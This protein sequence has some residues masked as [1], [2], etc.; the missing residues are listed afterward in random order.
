MKLIIYYYIYKVRFA[1]QKSK[2]KKWLRKK[3][4]LP[5]LLFTRIEIQLFDLKLKKMCKI[6]KKT[7]TVFSSDVNRHFLLYLHALSAKI[8]AVRKSKKSVG[9]IID[10]FGSNKKFNTV[11]EVLNCRFIK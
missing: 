11:I 7:T 9:R 6:N 2:I 5:N 4:E 10:T 1:Y 8:G 3:A